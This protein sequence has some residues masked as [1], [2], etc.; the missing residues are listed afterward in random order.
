MTAFKF[1]IP[2]EIFFG[3]NCVEKNAGVLAQYG[4]KCLIITGRR[5][6]KACGALSDV[7]SAL[8]R[9]GVRS[10]IFDRVENNP[11]VETAEA[12]GEAARQAGAEFV[13]GIGGGSPIDTAKA[14][15]VLATN[16]VSAMDLFKNQFEKPPLP[17]LAIPTTAG[18]GSEATPYSV[19]L[20]HG[21]QT[22]RSFGTRQTFPSAAFLDARYIRA[23]PRDATVNTAVDA[24][25]HA[26]EGLLAKRAAPLPD[27]LALEA[28]RIF[29]DALPELMEFKVSPETRTR[30][31]YASLLGGMVIAHSGVT[32]VHAMGYCYTYFK[33]IPHGRANG[34]LFAACLDYN[35]PVAAHK[36]EK[37]LG[38]LGVTNIEALGDMIEKLVGKPP[39]LSEE[40]IKKYAELTMLQK[41]SLSN[42]IRPVSESDAAQLW[43]KVGQKAR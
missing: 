18:T 8:N 34:L 28:I 10:E 26:V 31:L 3:D 27:L 35:Y 20:C 38:L 41:G 33:G 30:L 4:R 15:A 1:L 29:G 9:A 11:S 16:T 24:L 2:T 42:S 22:K 14:A 6:A 7:V 5:S 23:L 21:S 43:R 32:A 17:I 36:I 37:I 39:E 13:I 19:L 25:T 12:A 40:E